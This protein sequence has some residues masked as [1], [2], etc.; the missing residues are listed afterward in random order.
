MCFLR[1]HPRY[2]DIFIVQ[3]R[4]PCITGF[5]TAL[6]LWS[7]Y[8]SEEITFFLFLF[9]LPFMLPN[10]Q[11][12]MQGPLPTTCGHFWLMCWEQNARAVLML[13]RTVER[14]RVG[15]HGYSALLMRAHAQFRPTPC[16]GHEGLFFDHSTFS[17]SVIQFVFFLLRYLIFIVILVHIFCSF[18]H[19]AWA[20]TIFT[21][22][23]LHCEI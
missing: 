13:N 5:T 14:G 1:D 19:N 4:W 12:H 23:E 18:F 9:G 10:K 8:Y 15:N 17:S 3:C 11:T 22:P 20:S 2:T 21:H 6:S 16:W 7:S